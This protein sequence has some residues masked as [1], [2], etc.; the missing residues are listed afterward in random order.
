ME[1]KPRIR[2]IREVADMVAPGCANGF[3]QPLKQAYNAGYWAGE[4]VNQR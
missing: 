4:L 2:S 1:S 3:A